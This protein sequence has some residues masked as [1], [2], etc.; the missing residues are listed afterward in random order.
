MQI[1]QKKVQSTLNNMSITYNHIYASLVSEIE[2]NISKN[3]INIV[4]MG[5]GDGKLIAFLQSNLLQ[6]FPNVTFYIRGF[7]VSDSSVQNGEYFGKTLS[8][9]SNTHPTINWSSRL[10]QIKSSDKL[11]YEDSSI[12]FVVSNQVMEHVL[13]PKHTI[14]EISRVL[15]RGGKSIHLFPI[16]RYMFE[17]HLYLFFVHRIYNYDYLLLFIKIMSSIGLGKFRT[18]RKLFNATL[19]SFSE[20]HSDYIV[21]N[22][23]YLTKSELLRIC[24]KSSL[25]SSYRYTEH[26]Y[27][28]KLRQI[29]GMKLL[30]KYRSSTFIKF[31]LFPFLSRI[32]CITLFLEK[33]D[34]YPSYNNSN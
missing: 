22:T 8:Y 16:N 23:H 25:R 6:I 20:A 26:F 27:F 19:D 13:D 2:N 31:I 33:K 4:D 9:L 28:T 34:S 24:K 29:L 3:E 32:S 10:K 30:E 12:D 17:G 1:S 14:R 11:P 21:F 7:D 15:K 5:C 18:H